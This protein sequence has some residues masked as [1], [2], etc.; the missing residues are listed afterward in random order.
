M[1]RVTE[2]QLRRVARYEALMQKAERL[3]AT[4]ERS[5]SEDKA[6]RRHIAK[7]EAYYGSED[8]KKDFADD[9]AG[10]FPQDMKRGVLSEDGLYIL[11]EKYK[12]DIK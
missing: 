11:L 2:E 4:G 8:W 1:R 5:E 7:L 3:L 12:E 9:E 6:L 10:L